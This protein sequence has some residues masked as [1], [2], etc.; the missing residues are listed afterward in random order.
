MTFEDVVG[1]G[2]SDENTVAISFDTSWDVICEKIIT[3]LHTKAHEK[4]I[5]YHKPIYFY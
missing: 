1:L 3:I 5:Y 2:F 4:Y